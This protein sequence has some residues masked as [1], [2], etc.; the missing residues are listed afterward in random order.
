VPR[1]R[2]AGGLLPARLA[3]CR[4]QRVR[5]ARVLLEPHVPAQRVLHLRH[6]L[7]LQAQPRPPRFAPLH[8][9]VFRGVCGCA[10]AV[11]LMAR[12]VAC[13]GVRYRLRGQDRAGDRLR[14]RGEPRA[15]RRQEPLRRGHRHASDERLL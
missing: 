9:R 2:R 7:L 10:C 12:A 15:D 6:A 8:P 13:A 11:C 1:G 4:R 3:L 14:H 5:G